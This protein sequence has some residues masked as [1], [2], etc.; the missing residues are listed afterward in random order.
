MHVLPRDAL[1]CALRLKM[2]ETVFKTDFWRLRRRFS[3][4]R[5]RKRGNFARKFWK[6]RRIRRCA[7]LVRPAV[8]RAPERFFDRFWR[9]VFET[10]ILMCAVL[11]PENCVLFIIS[12]FENR[13]PP[14]GDDHFQVRQTHRST[15]CW[16]K[17]HFEIASIDANHAMHAN[18]RD[19]SGSRPTFGRSTGGLPS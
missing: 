1:G 11:K 3:N 13:A 9:K 17:S 14:L 10:E 12:S 18:M 15:R 2:R 6:W 19:P 16:S 7:R 4:F 5:R 8:G